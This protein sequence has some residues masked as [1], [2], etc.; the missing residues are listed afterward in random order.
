M[1]RF[2]YKRPGDEQTLEGGGSGGGNR[3]PSKWPQDIRISA[4][5]ERAILAKREAQK[6]AQIVQ[7]K[8][9]ARA[10]DEAR[11]LADKAAGKIK[12]VFPR[13]ESVENEGKAKGGTVKMAKGG[14]VSARADGC[15]QRGKTKGRIV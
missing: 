14:A 12:S 3:S 2:D 1:G 5:E 7:D 13:K 9:A 10:A 4:A 11:Y 8:E 6:K 15:A